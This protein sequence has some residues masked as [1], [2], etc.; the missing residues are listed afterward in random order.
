MPALLGVEF[1][2]LSDVGPP[3]LFEGDHRERVAQEVGVCFDQHVDLVAAVVGGGEHRLPAG[4]RHRQPV[5]V[6]PEHRRFQAVI[7]FPQKPPPLDRL[8]VLQ[9]HPVNTAGAEPV[10]HVRAGRVGDDQGSADALV[11]ARCPGLFDHLGPVPLDVGD[12]LLDAAVR[13][14]D[15]PGG[16]VLRDHPGQPEP[17]VS[18][19]GSAGGDLEDGDA[20]LLGQP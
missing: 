2:E 11:A 15:P 8:K 20:G 16:E 12:H 10:H 3:E 1:G 14:I 9:P 19:Q 18:A 5:L 6:Q 17:L 4:Y 7:G 13:D